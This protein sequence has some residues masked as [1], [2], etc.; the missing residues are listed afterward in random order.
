ME[1]QEWMGDLFSTF[2]KP[3]VHSVIRN[4]RFVGTVSQQRNNNSKSKTST[5]LPYRIGLLV[6]V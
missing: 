5:H 3:P 1:R 2:F 4:T 6:K